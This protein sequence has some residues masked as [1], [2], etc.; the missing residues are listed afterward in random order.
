MGGSVHIIY[1]FHFYIYKLNYFLINFFGP[2]NFLFD[3]TS[4][5]NL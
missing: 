3:L 5:I 2:P 1:Y 4:Q